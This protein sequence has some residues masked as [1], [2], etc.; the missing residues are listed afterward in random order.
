M[1]DGELVEVRVNGTPTVAMPSLYWHDDKGSH[2]VEL[3]AG[4]VEGQTIILAAPKAPFWSLLSFYLEPPVPL[5]PRVLSSIESRY[6]RVLSEKG[7]YAPGLPVTYTTLSEL[8]ASLGYWV[9]ITDTT[10]ANLLAQG[11][12]VPPTTT[13]ALHA[14]W[15]WVGYLPETV[16]PI[17]T[18]LASIEGS[19]LRVWGDRGAYQPDLEPQYITLW[20]LRPGE[21]YLMRVSQAVCLSYPA[22][23]TQVAATEPTVRPQSACPAIGRTPYLSLAYGPV[24]VGGQ[25]AAIGAIVE[26]I[27]PR[28]EVA[29]CT[30]VMAAGYFGV[31]A[32]YGEDATASPAIPGFHRGEPVAFRVNGRPVI[33][34]PALAWQDD[35]EAH[36]VKLRGEKQGVYLPW[37]GR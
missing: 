34:S 22:G 29:G 9:R 25:P 18:A 1:R 13:L 14:G 33:A 35:L 16:L 2:P 5:V 4:P 32:L 30:T 17:T 11:L 8:H 12:T 10:S 37:V 27:T 3:I 36:F 23:G 15:N 21:G 24:M 28:G 7:V 6:D 26:A 19:Y 31:M 20:D